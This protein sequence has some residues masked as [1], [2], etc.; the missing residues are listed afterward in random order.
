MISHHNHQWLGSLIADDEKWLLYIISTHR[1][2]GL[3]AA[4]TGTAVSRTDPYLKKVMW[5]I[6]WGINDIIHGEILP[7]SCTITADVFCQQ[8]GRVAEKL[9]GKQDWIYYLHDNTRPHVSKSTPWKIIEA[10]M[11][12]CFLSTLFS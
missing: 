3:S 11:D 2:Q 10:R 7:S 4:Q 1:R 6:W 5:S 9:K 12:Y 8:Q